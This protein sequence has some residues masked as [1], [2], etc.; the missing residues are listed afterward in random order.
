MPKRKRGGDLASSEAKRRK[1]KEQRKNETVEEREARLRSQRTRMST[2]RSRE[3]EEQRNERIEE[4]RIAT[5]SYNK[6]LRTQAT[7]E[8]ITLREARTR[9]S[10]QYNLTNEAFHYDPTKEYNKHKHVVIGKWITSA[11][12]ATRKNSVE[13]HQDSVA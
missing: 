6:R 8:N 7:H 4:S 11:N 2:V 1:Q 10:K 3:T 12:F 9:T 13:K 5:Q